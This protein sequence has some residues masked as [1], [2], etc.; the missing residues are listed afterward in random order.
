MFRMVTFRI[1]V[2]SGK[3]L[4]KAFSGSQAGFNL[5]DFVGIHH[6]HGL[7]AYLIMLHAD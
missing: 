5:L 4:E 3:H 7:C 2:R 1:L 6:S